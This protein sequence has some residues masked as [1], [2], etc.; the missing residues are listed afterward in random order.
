MRDTG[1]HASPF[2]IMPTLLFF[3]ATF[4]TP[5]LYQTVPIAFDERLVFVVSG[6]QEEWHTYDRECNR[7]RRTGKRIFKDLFDGPIQMLLPDVPVGSQS[8]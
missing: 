8:I 6:F 4:A 5:F 2:E 7:A 3:P 1:L